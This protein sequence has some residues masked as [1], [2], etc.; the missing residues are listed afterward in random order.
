MHT[1]LFLLTAVKVIEKKLNG[2][3]FHW[4]AVCVIVDVNIFN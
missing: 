4:R 1:H 3:N 2:G